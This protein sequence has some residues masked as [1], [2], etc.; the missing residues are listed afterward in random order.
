M[1][2]GVV[3]SGAQSVNDNEE[4]AMYYEKKAVEAQMEAA[5]MAD[6]ENRLTMLQIAKMWETM[7]RGR[8]R[9]S[10]D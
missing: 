6:L 1:A 2:S 10:Q 8:R 3:P 4:R 5:A 7:A 9:Q